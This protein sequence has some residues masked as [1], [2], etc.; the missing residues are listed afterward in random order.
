[1]SC[2]RQNIIPKQAHIKIKTANT[3]TAAKRTKM[4]E[5]SIH[6]KNEIKYLYKKKH[7]VKT[8]HTHYKSMTR[9]NGEIYGIPYS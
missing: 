7:Q 5:Q 8:L 2:P 1:M 3:T 9:T 4:Q 6:I